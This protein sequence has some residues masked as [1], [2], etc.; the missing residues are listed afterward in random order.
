MRNLYLTFYLC[1]FI[2]SALMEVVNLSVSVTK[3]SVTI[4]WEWQRKSEPVRVSR[5][6]A[7]LRK[8]SD[9]QCMWVNEPFHQICP[10]I[11]SRLQ[12]CYTKLLCIFYHLFA[13][14]TYILSFAALPL[15]P[16]D[17]QHTFYDLMP[18]A[19]YSVTL[20]ADNVS[21]SIVQMTTDF[22]EFHWTQNQIPFC[23]FFALQRWLHFFVVDFFSIQLESI[24]EAISAAPPGVWT[25]AF[26]HL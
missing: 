10:C 6:E 8:H 20:L 19:Q 2:F 1:V 26:V 17:Q 12:R 5:Y 14:A 4:M 13:N 25:A 22:G 11:F 15:W 16:D 23:G 18:N 7:V 21:K 24:I 3:T 9:K